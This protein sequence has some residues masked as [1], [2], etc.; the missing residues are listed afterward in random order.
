MEKD[1][2]SHNQRAGERPEGAPTDHTAHGA[3]P[4]NTEPIRGENRERLPLQ[5][6]GNRSIHD[7]KADRPSSNDT[8]GGQPRRTSPLDELGELAKR[9]NTTPERIEEQA[10]WRGVWQYQYGEDAER[11]SRGGTTWLR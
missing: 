4:G 6:A 3:T 5:P 10:K 7:E 2:A 9:N 8:E 11:T 1:N